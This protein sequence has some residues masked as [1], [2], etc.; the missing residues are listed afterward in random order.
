MLQGQGLRQAGQADLQH[1][2]QEQGRDHQ[3]PGAN[4]RHVRHVQR[5]AGRQPQRDLQSVIL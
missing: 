2:R 3:L 1:V 4:G 5:N